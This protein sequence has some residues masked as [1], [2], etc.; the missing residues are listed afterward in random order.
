MLYYQW[1]V[2][3]KFI[4]LSVRTVTEFSVVF[5]YF[6]WQ[7]QTDLLSRYAQIRAP[8]RDDRIVQQSAIKCPTRAT[9][10]Y[11]SL[12]LCSLQVP[13]LSKCSIRVNISARWE[14]LRKTPLVQRNL[15]QHLFTFSSS[16]LYKNTLH[17][18]RAP[19]TILARP[20]PS[21]PM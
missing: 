11:G 16:T 10:V 19:S 3:P 17:S 20:T 9:C 15:R 2:S 7:L 5:V 6:S 1:K 8:H 14:I 4:F 18:A 12:Y 13:R 21:L